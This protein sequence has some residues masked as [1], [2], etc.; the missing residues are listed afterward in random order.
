MFQLSC[1]QNYII[2]PPSNSRHTSW[3]IPEFGNKNRS[4]L[5]KP[6]L[7]LPSHFL[8]F[9]FKINTWCKLGTFC[10]N[11]LC[12]LAFLFSTKVSWILKEKNME[13]TFSNGTNKKVFLNMLFCFKLSV[14]LEFQ[15]AIPWAFYME[16]KKKN[17]W[18]LCNKATI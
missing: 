9:S 4:L 3:N 18:N 13:V 6:T 12:I 7:L 15:I 2:L 11:V 16:K 5:M 1:T 17:G 8:T 14:I 10:N